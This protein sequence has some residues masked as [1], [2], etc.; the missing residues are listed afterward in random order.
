[1]LQKA[2]L[3]HFRAT[4]P[5]KGGVDELL[6]NF[7]EPGDKV[8]EIF[9]SWDTSRTVTNRTYYGNTDIK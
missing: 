3:L 6:Q 7:T 4:N 2:V 5:V 9:N 8:L 1:M